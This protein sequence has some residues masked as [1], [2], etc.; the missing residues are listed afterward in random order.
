MVLNHCL[1]SFHFRLRFL[2]SISCRKDLLVINCLSFCLSRK[3]LNHPHVYLILIYPLYLKD[4]FTGYRNFVDGCFLSAGYIRAL[5][6]L[7]WTSHSS[8]CLTLIAPTSITATGTSNVKLLSTNTLRI[9][10]FPSSKLWIRS[11]NRYWEWGCQ[12]AARQLK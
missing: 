5:Q 8:F 3:V 11:N 12:G 2:I 4:S 7:L 9:G 1:V 6:S 10:L